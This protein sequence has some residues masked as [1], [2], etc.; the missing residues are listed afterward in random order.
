[1]IQSFRVA[2]LG[3]NFDYYALTVSLL[4]SALLLFVGCR[5]FRR[6]QRTFADCI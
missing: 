4:M 2:V 5:Y 3:G 6:V 1:L